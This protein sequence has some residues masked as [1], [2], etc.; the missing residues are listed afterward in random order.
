MVSGNRRRSNLFFS[1]VCGG[2]YYESKTLKNRGSR[3]INILNCSPNGSCISPKM[4]QRA[5]GLFV[6]HLVKC[7]ALHWE[8]LIR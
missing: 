2:R 1:L 7:P 5:D 3:N 8:I 6:G 4:T